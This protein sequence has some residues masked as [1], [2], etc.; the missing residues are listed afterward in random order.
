MAD[1]RA[2]DVEAYVTTFGVNS[3]NAS[4]RAESLKGFLTYA[5]KHKLMSEKL[6]SHVRVRRAGVRGRGQ[7]TQMEEKPQLHLTREGIAA[8]EEELEMLKARRPKIAQELRDAMADKDFRE[9]A[10][11]DAARDTQGQTEARIRELEGML[12]HAV[13]LEDG[14]TKGDRAGV[15]SNVTLSNLATGTKLQ[16]LLVSSAEARPTAGRL[17]VASPVGQAIVGKR[18]GDEVEVQAPSGT[19]RFRVESVE[20]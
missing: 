4:T 16:Y 19:V 8:L 11:L 3:P 12:R 1:I 17:S 18:A 2:P 7:P 6:V 14:G 5:H 13:V 10:P 15:G 9:N 20:A